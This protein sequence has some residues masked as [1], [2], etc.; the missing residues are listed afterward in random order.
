M[1]PD[2]RSNRHFLCRSYVEIPRSAA[3]PVS[4]AYLAKL[5]RKKSAPA[6]PFDRY[7]RVDFTV[8]VGAFGLL[9]GYHLTHFP[10]S[11]LVENWARLDAFKLN[12]IGAFVEGA[13]TRLKWGDR[14]Y[15]LVRRA[16]DILV[17]GNRVPVVWDEQG[18][19]WFECGTCGRRRRAKRRSIQFVE[20]LT[21]DGPTVFDHVCRMGWRASCRSGR[22]RRTAAGGQG[23][24]S[25]RR[26][27]RARRC[28][29]SARR[30]G[31]K[32]GSVG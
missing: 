3:P 11:H 23:R 29:G 26:T 24:G 2:G 13:T 28:A 14:G 17:N 8:M 22:M 32:Q 1:K 20:H 18:R 27:R 15:R 4:P 19:P 16:P 21:G 12:R 30:S 10:G 7:R 25:R 6:V 9:D 31:A 5:S